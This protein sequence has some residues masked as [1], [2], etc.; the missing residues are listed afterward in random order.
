M[1]RSP[2]TSGWPGGQDRTLTVP[3]PLTAREAHTTPEATVNPISSL[4]DEH[5]LD[6]IA[7]ILG[8]RG[9]PG[10]WG[11][12]YTA[13]S[14]TAVCRDRGIPGH[15]TGCGAAGYLTA[16]ETAAETAA[17]LGTTIPTVNKW[18]RA[19]GASTPSP[20]TTAAATSTAPGSNPQPRAYHRRAGRRS[21]RPHVS[22]VQFSRKPENVRRHATNTTTDTRSA[23]TA[24]PAPKHSLTVGEG[25]I[26]KPTLS[27]SRCGSRR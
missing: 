3:H 2:R 9:I 11:R 4:L 14:L 10:G 19:G 8:E 12:P 24:P 5:P 25:S 1:T 6:E 26:V 27:N 17:R 23:G 13:R 20:S 15:G 22:T 7:V 21:R 16:A 18:Q